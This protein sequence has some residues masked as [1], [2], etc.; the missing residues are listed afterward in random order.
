MNKSAILLAILRCQP[1]CRLRRLFRVE[2]VQSDSKCYW[3]MEYDVCSLR[4]TRFNSASEHGIDREFQPER[5]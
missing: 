3:S 2:L 4:H 5:Q 1:A